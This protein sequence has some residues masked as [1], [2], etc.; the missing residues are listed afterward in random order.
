MGGVVPPRNIPAVVSSVAAINL[1]KK[2]TPTTILNTLYKAKAL[3]RK[4]LCLLFLKHLV[5]V[6]L[7]ILCALIDLPWDTYRTK[8]Q[9]E[10]KTYRVRA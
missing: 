6:S 2:D 10:G 9:K 5:G 8:T 7:G 4:D 3:D 1:T